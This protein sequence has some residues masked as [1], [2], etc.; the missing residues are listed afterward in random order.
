MFIL[1][2]LVTAVLLVLPDGLANAAAVYFVISP[3]IYEMDYIAKN[4][5]NYKKMRFLRKSRL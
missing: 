3:S 1:F 2:L 5:W 4:L